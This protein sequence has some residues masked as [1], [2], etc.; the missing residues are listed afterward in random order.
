MGDQARTV[1]HATREHRRDDNGVGPRV[2][3][4]KRTFQYIGLSP[5]QAYRLEAAGRFP[6]RIK[7]GANSSAYLVEELDAWINEKAAARA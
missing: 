6:K 4:P 5:A 2:L 7:L 1:E 3:R